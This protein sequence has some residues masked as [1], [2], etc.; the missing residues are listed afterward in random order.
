M[1][2]VSL[3][4][5]TFQHADGVG[6]LAEKMLW[7]AGARTW[8]DYLA[9]PESTKWPLSELQRSMLKP[10][11]EESQARLADED[12][13]WF[14]SRLPVK[15]HWR[16]VPAF[17]HR[18]GFLDI[19]T[20]GMMDA[21]HITVVGLY[22]G[23]TVHQFVKGKNLHEFPEAMAEVAMI[24]TFFGTGFDI[25]FLK[26]E[27]VGLQFPQM[28]VDLC[29]HFR[30]LGMKGG[31]KSIENQLGIFRSNATTGLNGMD[32]VRLWH[33][34]ELGREKSLET[35]LAYNAD[36][37]RNMSDLLSEGYRRMARTL[38]VG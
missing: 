24:V 30:R 29:Y 21:G 15:E 37:V 3:L 17:G 2:V 14:A 25:P 28:H 22:D 38:L 34:A 23:R 18:L 9:N 26:K 20:T 32:A 31:L 11:I 6:P 33:E 10:V 12:F 8:S 4:E 7:E 1:A 27:F 35:L 16:A 13:E 36:D 5:S 19:E